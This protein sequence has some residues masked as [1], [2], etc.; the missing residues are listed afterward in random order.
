[1]QSRGRVRWRSQLD[2]ALRDIAEGVMS[3][4]EERWVRDVESAHSLP[5]TW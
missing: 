3:P 5:S 2:L 4:L 1:M